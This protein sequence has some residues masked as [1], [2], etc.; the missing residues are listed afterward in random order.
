MSSTKFFKDLV[1]FLPKHVS[2]IKSY[3]HALLAF[4]SFFIISYLIMN[5]LDFQL[6]VDNDGI[7]SENEERVKKIIQI[8]I[9]FIISVFIA[10]LTFNASWKIRNRVNK[11]HATYARWFNFYQ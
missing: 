1:E 5:K 2:P 3:T 8:A 11:N 9:S 7:E 6:D 10:D 4:I